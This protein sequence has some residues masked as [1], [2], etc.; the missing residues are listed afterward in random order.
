MRKLQTIAIGAIFGIMLAWGSAYASPAQECSAN[1]RNTADQ[2]VVELVNSLEDECRYQLDAEGN[3][4][5]APKGFLY[6]EDLSIVP[7]SFYAS[8]ASDTYY[9]PTIASTT[10]EGCFVFDLEQPN[11]EA[12]DETAARLMDMGWVGDPTD[13]KEALYNPECFV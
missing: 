5:E 6:A 1:F 8:S 13:S 9:D 12:V 11:P 3:L 7:V 4:P 10:V 2:E